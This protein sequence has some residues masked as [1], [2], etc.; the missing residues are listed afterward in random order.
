MPQLARAVRR[1]RTSCPCST[2]QAR[3]PHRRTLSGTASASPLPA[4]PQT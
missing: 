4:W 3:H 1:Q 2:A